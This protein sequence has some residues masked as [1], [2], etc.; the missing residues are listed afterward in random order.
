MRFVLPS[1]LLGICLS[2]AAVTPDDAIRE[3]NRTLDAPLRRAGLAAPPGLAARMAAIPVPGISIAVIH[4]GELHWAQGFGEALAGVPV[5]PQTRFQAGSISKPVAAL[6]ALSLAQQQGVDFDADLRPML[7]RWQPAAEDGPPRYTLRRL[8]S[9]SAGLGQHG[10]DGYPI[11]A[12]LPSLAQILDGAPPA[13]SGPV[14][15]VQPA[16][17][18]WRYSGGG[19]TIVQLWVEDQLGRAFADVMQSL[20]LAPLG[21]SHSHYE[22]PPQDA[23]YPYAHAHQGRVAEPGGFRVYPEREAAGLWTTPSDL[24]QMLMAVQR[25]RAGQASALSPEVVR[26]ATTVVLA[27]SG[28][29]FFIEGQRFGHDGS[30]QGFE[31]L[32]SADLDG[33]EGVVIMANGQNSWKMF[34]AIVRTLARVYGWT[35]RVAPLAVADQRLPVAS[36]A[37][38]GQYAV[39]DRKPLRIRTQAGALL[40]DSGPGHWHRLWR[41]EN[42]SYA[43]DDNGPRDLRFTPAG[44]LWPGSE[45]PLPRQALTPLKLPTIHWRGSL[46]DWQAALPLRAAGTGRWLLDLNLPAG[47]QDFKLGDADWQQVDLGSP[48]GRVLLTGAWQRLAP[49]GGNL[50]LDLPRAGRYRLELQMSDSP[51]PARLRLSVMPGTATP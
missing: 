47:K 30:N 27:P 41:T 11:G 29:G 3:L 39:T 5:T 15:P 12:P 24:A 14:R 44:L 34:E 19:T 9:H 31:S 40:I 8:L 28:A 35:D 20:V 10:F 26:A 21:M 1:L 42:G 45:R 50:L 37:W 46:N 4:K 32:S 51:Q 25:A 36:P 33:G 49:R 48:D 38:V 22:Q 43:T 18:A 6:G 16:G 23:R 7:K 17:Q 13:N 2:A